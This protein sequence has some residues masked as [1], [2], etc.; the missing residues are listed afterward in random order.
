MSRKDEQDEAILGLVEAVGALADVVSALLAEVAAL[1]S[2]QSTV[3]YVNPTPQ[4]LSRTSTHGQMARPG[5]P[6]Q[7]ARRHGRS[8]L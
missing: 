7:G 6:A 4:S 5:Y 2:R 1:K 8:S 3:W